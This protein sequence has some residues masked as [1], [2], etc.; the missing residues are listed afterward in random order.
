MQLFRS[1]EHLQRWRAPRRPSPGGEMSLETMWK[2][3]DAWYRDRL[4]PAWRRKS[5]QEAEDLFRQL[6]LDGEY[7]TF[8]R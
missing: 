5:A 6:G 1:E 7:W 2:L 4:D 8:D 3:A